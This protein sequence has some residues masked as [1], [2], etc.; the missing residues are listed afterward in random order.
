[1]LCESSG[2]ATAETSSALRKMF[3]SILHSVAL[4]RPK[5]PRKQLQERFSDMK[6]ARLF[7]RLVAQQNAPGKSTGEG[8]AQAAMTELKK[9]LDNAETSMVPGRGLAAPNPTSADSAAPADSLS[10]ISPM[11][12][13]LTDA[14]ILPAEVGR[15]ILSSLC[16]D[17]WH[18]SMFKH[19]KLSLWIRLL[20]LHESRRKEG[21]DG[22]TLTRDD[23]ISLSSMDVT[24]VT[25]RNWLTSGNTLKTLDDTLLTDPFEFERL[26]VSLQILERIE[27][28]TQQTSGV[29]WSTVDEKLR[30][31]V[32]AEIKMPVVKDRPKFL[33]NLLHQKRQL[34][35][36]PSDFTRKLDD[37][38]AFLRSIPHTF[39]TITDVEVK[40]VND[41]LHALE[42]GQV[43][44]KL[45]CEG[46][47]STFVY[48]Y[49]HY[50]LNGKK[51]IFVTPYFIVNTLLSWHG[52]ACIRLKR[53]PR[54]LSQVL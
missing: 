42:Q 19:G 22:T 23:L 35:Q 39:S 52:E 50:D 8:A 10:P 46:A 9:F 33:K 47:V 44:P 27:R 26:F 40:W 21:G 36:V 12:R 1:M 28:R 4:D 38:E 25:L 32:V 7:R 53:E 49:Q 30:A 15:T 41:I 18:K 14:S 43:G 6:C 51:D 24:I 3:E 20:E 2:N 34:W 37:M 45:F 29:L 31:E 13:F 5:D 16:R 11:L 54:D 48:S 17:Q